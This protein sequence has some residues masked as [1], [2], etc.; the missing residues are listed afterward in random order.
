V[1]LLPVESVK[2]RNGRGRE[3][4]SKAKAFPWSIFKL[5]QVIMRDK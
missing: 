5:K 3:A 2:W 4:G 1:T